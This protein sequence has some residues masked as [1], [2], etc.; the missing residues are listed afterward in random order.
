MTGIWSKFKRDS[1][2]QFEEIQD[3]AFH[4]E[5]LQSILLEFD[6]NRASE[7]T[8]LIWYFQE[9]LKPSIKAEMKSQVD[10]YEHWEELVKKT[11][12]AEAKAALRPVSYIRKMDQDCRRGNW[13]AYTTTAKS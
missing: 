9:A 8:D 3:S 12:V 13:P 5:H 6:V 11:V 1:Q 7:E 4:L 2:Y 10:E